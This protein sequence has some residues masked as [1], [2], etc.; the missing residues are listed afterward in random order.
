[1][2]RVT[3]RALCVLAAVASGYA[4]GGEPQLISPAAVAL[5]PPIQAPDEDW[6][7]YGLRLNIG[8]GEH[9]EVFGVD[10]GVAGGVTERLQGLQVNFLVNYDQG[11]SQALQIAGLFNYN[12]GTFHGLAIAGLV[13]LA[14][15][16]KEALGIQIAFIANVATTASAL[17]IGAVNVAA[18]NME[19][20]QIGV[21]NYA[22]E[23]SGVQIG[24]INISPDGPI[25]FMPV[26]N[27]AF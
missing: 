24:V 13:N 17:Q 4:L 18:K 12:A 26:L 23:L 21:V 15:D 11:D 16:S 14:Q 9:R 7:I 25:E 27:F 5:C 2:R 6:S 22:R 19:G 3:L 10:T 1:M 20:V 8:Y